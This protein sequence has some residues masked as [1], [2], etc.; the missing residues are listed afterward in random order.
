MILTD[1]AVRSSKTRGALAAEPVDS[2]DT[3]AAIV[4]KKG[5]RGRDTEGERKN[6]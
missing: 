1:S 6:D 4:A 2:V 5:K 3:D